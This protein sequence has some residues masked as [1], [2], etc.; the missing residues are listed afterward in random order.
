MSS[1]EEDNSLF[2]GSAAPNVVPSQQIP[3]SQHAQNAGQWQSRGK[4][5]GR[6]G[7]GGRGA[8]SLGEPAS[9]GAGVTPPGSNALVLGDGDPTDG[10][11]YTGISIRDLEFRLRA[12]ND[13]AESSLF[14]DDESD[15]PSRRK[16]PG[17]AS[18]SK[19]KQKAP[20]HR[21]SSEGDLANAVFGGSD[22]DDDDDDELDGED[23]ESEIVSESASQM[24]PCTPIK[25]ERCPGCFLDR[26]IVQQVEHFVRENATNMSEVPL[27]KAAA[28]FYSQRVVAQQKREGVRVARWQW[29]SVREHFSLHVVDPVLARISVIRTLQAIRSFSE[30]NLVRVE[31]NGTKQLDNKQIELLLKVAAMQSKELSLLD[32]ARMPPPPSRSGRG[33]VGSSSNAN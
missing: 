8:A 16:R 2:G 33:A 20:K 13:G 9:N 23:G 21:V 26:A 17:A 19:R 32:S 31:E 5:R 7:K 24:G 6:G 4:G 27:F 3:A 11:T 10:P 1:D 15:A 12:N 30:T 14:T 18:S 22:D 28:L 29:K 25:G